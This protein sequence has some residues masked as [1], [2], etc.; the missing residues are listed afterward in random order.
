MQYKLLYAYLFVLLSLP[1][2]AQKDALPIKS[3][4]T[5]VFN[6]LFKRDFKIAPLNVFFGAFLLSYEQLLKRQTSWEAHLLIAPANKSLSSLRLNSTDV[7]LSI[8]LKAFGATKKDKSLMQGWYFRPELGIGLSKYTY[9]TK[10]YQS[11]T[12]S[13]ETSKIPTI[14]W[15]AFTSA[16]HQSIWG[17]RFVFDSY[18]GVGVRSYHSN[19]NNPDFFTYLHKARNIGVLL[20]APNNSSSIVLGLTGG[21]T[22][23]FLF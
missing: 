6:I 21:M 11:G 5:Q 22:M 7:L 20:N 23:G 8:S 12:S 9:Q 14:T 4:S 13:Y 3:D 1:L 15:R 2:V 19:E 16:G 10:T 18:L 17:K